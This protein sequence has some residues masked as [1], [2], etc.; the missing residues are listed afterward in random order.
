L[1]DAI[2]EQSAK[3]RRVSAIAEAAPT[4]EEVAEALDYHRMHGGPQHN[5]TPQP[6]A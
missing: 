6:I 2:A 4:T 3:L 5:G 1:R